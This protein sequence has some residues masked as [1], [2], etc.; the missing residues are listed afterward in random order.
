MGEKYRITGVEPF[1]HPLVVPHLIMFPMAYVE[2]RV[3][4]DAAPGEAGAAEVGLSRDAGMRS[5]ARAKIVPRDAMFAR[6]IASTLTPYLRERTA[7]IRE[8][9]MIF[10]SACFGSRWN[11]RPYSSLGRDPPDRHPSESICIAYSMKD[12]RTTR[13]LLLTAASYHYEQISN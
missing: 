5:M 1:I 9:E 2:E 7:C 10:R 13:S 11:M 6:R 4:E 3:L 12:E 8:T